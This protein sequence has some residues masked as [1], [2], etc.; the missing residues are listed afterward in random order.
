MITTLVILG[1]A[2]FAV[3][4]SLVALLPVWVRQTYDW[5][6][7][8]AVGGIAYGLSFIPYERVLIA[9]AAVGMV[10]VLHTISRAEGTPAEPPEFHLPY[11][12]RGRDRARGNRVPGLP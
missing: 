1:L 12:R 7:P 9:I 11:L 5:L 4:E 2:A 6:F 3:W 10:G 8:L